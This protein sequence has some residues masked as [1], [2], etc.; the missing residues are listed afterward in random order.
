PPEQPPAPPE[1]PP[2]PPEQ[3]PVPPEQPPA[4]PEQP[5]A[6][7]AMGWGEPK[8][9]SFNWKSLWW[10]AAIVVAALVVSVSIRSCGKSKPDSTAPTATIVA[11]CNYSFYTLEEGGKD[12]ARR[13]N[14]LMGQGCK[15]LNLNGFDP[16]TACEYGADHIMRCKLPPQGT[17]VIDFNA[18]VQW[19]DYG[20]EQFLPVAVIATAKK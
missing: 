3:P 4:T 14:G 17:L 11:D 5:P 18:N 2:V 6:P 19:K 9:S 12:I 7:F 15:A 16:K 10:L 20:S 13:A 1:Q 8:R